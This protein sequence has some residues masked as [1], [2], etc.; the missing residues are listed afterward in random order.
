LRPTEQSRSG[1][2][3]DHCWIAGCAELCNN[4]QMYLISYVRQGD[5]VYEM[6]WTTMRGVEV[7]DNHYALMDLTVYRRQEP[8]ED[9]PDGWP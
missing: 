8:Y 2:P 9:P 1:P 5:R 4:G 7:M 3:H 6:Y